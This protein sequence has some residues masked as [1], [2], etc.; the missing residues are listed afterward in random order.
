MEPSYRSGDIV[1]CFRTKQIKEND[2]IAFKTSDYGL[3]LKRV[4][5]LVLGKFKVSSDNPSY[6]STIL[7]EEHEVENIVGKVL[8][9]LNSLKSFLNPLS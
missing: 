5:S 8:F 9:S 2:V 1:V 3:V 4:S 6:D 7:N